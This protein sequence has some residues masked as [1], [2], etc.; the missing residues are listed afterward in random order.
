MFTFEIEHKNKILIPSHYRPTRNTHT[1]PNNDQQK[2]KQIHTGDLCR[3]RSQT[4]S[5][6]RQCSRGLRSEMSLV[7]T[8]LCR[9]DILMVT[10]W[11]IGSVQLEINSFSGTVRPCYGRVETRNKVSSH[12]TPWVI[13]SIFVWACTL[14]SSTW[15][16]ITQT[17]RSGKIATP[18]S[19]IL[20]FLNKI[21][22]WTF[23]FH[24]LVHLLT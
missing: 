6:S 3:Q 1:A 15:Q 21:I 13:T 18:T 12:C 20:Y 10:K 11:E 17:K 2:I 23:L 9:D 24:Y 7:V 8:F 16:Y 14:I 5:L 22:V 19:K 4:R